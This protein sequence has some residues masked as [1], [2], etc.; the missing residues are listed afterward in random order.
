[1]SIGEVDT[2]GVFRQDTVGDS[3][4]KSEIPFP[5]VSYLIWLVFIIIL[6][7]LLINQLVCI[8]KQKEI[9]NSQVQTL[10]F[11]FNL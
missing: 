6:P 11:D 8:W 3:D 4:T 1:M 7:L 5:V 10:Q 9:C 2:D